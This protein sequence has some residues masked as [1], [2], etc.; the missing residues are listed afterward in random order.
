MLQFLLP[1]LFLALVSQAQAASLVNLNTAD[2]QLLDTLPG[3]GP[4]RAAAIIE[5]RAKHGSFE[6]IEDLDAVPGIGPVT[7]GNITNLA[8]VGESAQ[9]PA[10]QPTQALSSSPKS[11]AEDRALS[12][13]SKPMYEEEVVV[14]PAE[15]AQTAA[16]GAPVLESAPAVQSS[17]FTS[18][19][20]YGF[21]GL[22]FFSGAALALLS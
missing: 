10:V 9:A 13:E 16:A 6:H 20:F 22:L 19:W 2:A 15:V 4:A 3:I 1:V 21:L 7:I 18:P 8:T 11:R 12:K 5:Y 14:A 17:I